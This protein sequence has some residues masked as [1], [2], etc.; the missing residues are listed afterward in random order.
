MSDTI[1]AQAAPQAGTA[2]AQIAPTNLVAAF[3]KKGGI[4]GIVAAVEVEARGQAAK[5][6]VTKPADRK[7]MNSL[8]YKIARSKTVLDDTGKDLQ[9]DAKKI[10]DA[11]NADRKLGRDRLEALQD[12]IK[13]PAVRFEQIEKDR[14]A[15]HEDALAAIVAMGNVEG[16]DSHEIMARLWGVP[17][18][19]GRQWQ[20][21][22]EKA[23]KTIAEVLLSLTVAHAAAVENEA[24]AEEVERLRQVEADRIAAENEQKRIERE[25]Q[26]ARDAAALA[27]M[28]AEAKAEEARRAAA[29]ALA[30]A[31]ATA[32][33]LADEAE[34][35]R[36]KAHCDAL[37]D[38]DAASGFALGSS[39]ATIRA[40]LEAFRRRP[41]R[42]W[43]EFADE[44]ASDIE[45][46]ISHL[47]EYLAKA[48]QREQEASE[49][50]RIVAEDRAKADAAAAVAAEQERVARIATE[51]QAVAEK[52]ARNVV[53][54]R[55][56]N[57][58]ARDDML[59]AVLRAENPHASDA[60]LV[61]MI[62]KAIVTAIAKG[63][64]R[65]VHIQY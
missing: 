65:H 20:E 34:D 19:E 6:D 21:F 8:A 11:I 30:Q 28:Q 62:A 12:E 1:E 9:A 37:A 59:A 36:I 35:N 7:A 47:E 10:V 13:A 40:T 60:A 29:L 23:D 43:E 57:S 58:N 44:A 33:R 63:L 54:Q 42:N 38:L 61:D 15:A 4:E 39:A 46:G 45:G 51:K 2:I 48:E 27:T 26:I 53:H 17:T 18:V 49:K 5:L 52:W 25:E 3:S 50:A 24:A 41:A 64:I 16:L 55:Q 31:Q 56:V 32:K 22:T 14:V